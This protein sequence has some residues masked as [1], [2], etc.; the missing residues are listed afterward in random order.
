MLHAVAATHV[1]ERKHESTINC[2]KEIW[3]PGHKFN[4]EPEVRFFFVIET[5]IPLGESDECSSAVSDDSLACV[6]SCHNSR[7]SNVLLDEILVV[8]FGCS[9]NKIFCSCRE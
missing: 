6:V 5:E 9:V 1:C 3:T 4:S 2:Y 7:A 8:I